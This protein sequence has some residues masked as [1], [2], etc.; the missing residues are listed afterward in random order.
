[1]KLKCTPS[2]C[3][4]FQVGWFL[5]GCLETAPDG[6]DANAYRDAADDKILAIMA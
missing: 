6:K 5:W 2:L 4:S 1:M 3:N